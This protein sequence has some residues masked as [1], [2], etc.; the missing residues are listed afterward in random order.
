MSITYFYRNHKVGYSIK[1]VSDLFVNKFEDKT[2]VEVPSPFASLSSILKN[3]YCAFKHRNK[4]GINHI[5]GDIHYCILPLMFCKTILTIHDC[6]QYDHTKGLKK[7]II[8]YLWFVLP[9]KFATK[10]VCISESTK[11]AVLRFTKRGDILVIPNAV[12]PKYKYAPKTFD[13]NNVNILLIGTNWNKNI[14]RTIQAVKDI[15]C[16]LTIIGPLTNAQLEMLQKTNVKYINKKDL[17]DEQ[18]HQEYVNCD[19]VSFCSLF[20]G[21]GMPIIEAQAV[22][23]PVVTSNLAPMNE[24]AGNGA[25]L[26]NPC[27]TNAIGNAIKEIISDGATKD[28]LLRY[29]EDNVKQFDLSTVVEQYSRLY[30]SII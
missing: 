23:R 26:V 30:K 9:L 11:Q 10:V 18:I 17:T 20:E 25:I 13:A 27:D 16:T 19:I 7:M 3:M 6:T 15:N 29:G 5:T 14:E 8:K 4:N 21:F 24:I 2:I 28:T 22:G 12:D 1:K